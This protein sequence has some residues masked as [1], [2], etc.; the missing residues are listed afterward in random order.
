MTE[1]D[2][3]PARSFLDQTV[4][5]EDP[6]HEPEAVDEPARPRHV[7]YPTAPAPPLT[8]KERRAN[9]IRKAAWTFGPSAAFLA[10]AGLADDTDSELRR[11]DRTPVEQ[12]D[13]AEQTHF[14]D[15]AGYG[16]AGSGL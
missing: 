15:S 9:T 7:Q 1:H 2:D 6:W 8:P 16:E 12:P 10:G 3:D 11:A 5:R 13:E 14:D 4:P